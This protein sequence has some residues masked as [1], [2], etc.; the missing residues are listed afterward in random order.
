MRFLPVDSSEL[1]SNELVWNWS[2]ACPPCQ[3]NMRQHQNYI[4]RMRIFS[5]LHSTQ[6]LDV[7][8]VNMDDDG[9]FKDVNPFF[10]TT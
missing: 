4:M 5:D 2:G 9:S 7:A 8:T 3:Y 1:Q 10:W 6:N